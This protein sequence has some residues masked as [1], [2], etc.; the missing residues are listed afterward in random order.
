MTHP[1]RSRLKVLLVTT[2]FPVGPNKASGIFVKRL[3][4]TLSRQVSLT[5]LTPGTF[6]QVNL[7]VDYQVNCFRYA[8]I[9]WQRLA[10]EPGG[11]LVALRSKPWLMLLLPA[12][13]VALFT[14]VLHH[15]KQADVIHA[16]WSITGLISG[17]AAL[18]IGK[19]VITTLRGSD[20]NSISHS[21]ISR[22]VT[23][24]T[25]RLNRMVVAVSDAIASE[26]C[27]LWPTQADKVY[28]VPN[29]VDEGL[30]TL[31]KTTKHHDLI[32]MTIGN[33]IPL[34]DVATLIH[35]FPSIQEIAQLR[36]VGEGVERSSLELL[37]KQLG[38]SERIDFVGA[39][40]PDEV[41]T[42]LS[43]ADIFVLS[44]HS[45]GRPNVILEAMAAG[46]AI[47][48][49]DLP[50]VRELL[51]ED[52]SGLFYR[53]GD[54]EALAGLLVRLTASRKLRSQLGEHARS[55]IVEMGLTWLACGARY[56][57]L[58]G[59]IQGGR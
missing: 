59:K 48:S 58:Y 30:L 51:E 5:V 45:E 25:L 1:G 39:I 2:S 29:G 8:P 21:V 26:L 19:P 56:V 40:P 34:K 54:T 13:L 15:G 10:H 27:Q 49:S 7:A 24:L 3:A 43:M 9:K 44:S 16:N 50:G 6:E 55:R 17:I 20:V 38:L 22:T 11:I 31:S 12:F 47:I 37:T 28:V 33:L 42:E 52:V 32:I 57:D 53:P 41:K 23:A 36:V 14:G 4:D 46:C 35:A 18:F